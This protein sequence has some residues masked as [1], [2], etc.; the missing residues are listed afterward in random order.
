MQKV[1]LLP[2]FTQKNTSLIAD[3]RL[4]DFNEMFASMKKDVDYAMLWHSAISGRL[5]VNVASAYCS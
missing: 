5:G 1:I 4:V 3:L 2:K